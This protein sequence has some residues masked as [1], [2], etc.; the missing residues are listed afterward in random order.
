MLSRTWQ[1]LLKGIP[2]V[3]AA[4]RPVSAGEMVLIRI[5]HAA[6]LP[7][8]D[9]AL[10]S[11]DDGSRR[12]RSGAPPA[13]ASAP[14]GGGNGVSAVAEDP[15][16]RAQRRRPDDAPRRGRACAGAGVPREEPAALAST[17]SP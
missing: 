6:N 2:E 10:K 7:T 11:L 8:L 4:N 5:A 9:E 12:G 17:P 13:R 16:D 14:A 1:M 15:H 3:Q